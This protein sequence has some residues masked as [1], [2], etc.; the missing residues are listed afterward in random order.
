MTDN[1]IFNNEQ[2][3]HE[4]QNFYLE[5]VNEAKHE[6]KTATPTTPTKKTVG[7][8]K[9]GRTEKLTLYTTAETSEALNMLV[10]EYGTNITELLNKIIGNYLA[11]Q[12]KQIAWLKERKQEFSN[13]FTNEKSQ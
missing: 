7:R 2:E 8:P 5:A 9:T 12:S 4:K 6:E 3:Q 1:G 11:T 10:A 13:L